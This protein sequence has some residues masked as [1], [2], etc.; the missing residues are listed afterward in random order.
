[1]KNLNSL[2]PDL[3]LDKE[4][5]AKMKEKRPNISHVENYFNIYCTISHNLDFTKVLNTFLRTLLI[6]LSSFVLKQIIEIFAVINLKSSYNLFHA[7]SMHY[8]HKI[9]NA[10]SLLSVCKLLTTVLLKRSDSYY[11]VP[12]HRE[13]NILNQNLCFLFKKS[14]NMF[15]ILS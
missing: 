14:F 5:L 2:N 15:F 8:C 7:L 10:F 13:R 11:C 4:K 9:C 1:M 3:N 6:S 12:C